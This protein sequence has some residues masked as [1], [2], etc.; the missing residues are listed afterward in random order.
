MSRRHFVSE[1][2]SSPLKDVQATDER[3]PERLK[4]P[5]RRVSRAW[6]TQS[7]KLD[8]ETIASKRS[9]AARAVEPSSGDSSS[10][11]LDLS[12]GAKHQVKQDGG[13]SGTRKGKV[14]EQRELNLDTMTT[15]E[16]EQL[17]WQ[18]RIGRNGESSAAA[19]E[20]P[21][22]GEWQIQVVNVN[23]D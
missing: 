18:E 13:A 17:A 20:K 11:L 6:L 16:L 21:S 15:E 5:S 23:C 14:R 12:I 10:F 1:M 8:Q 19:V 2:S 7:P 4:R 3:Q 9:R 22:R